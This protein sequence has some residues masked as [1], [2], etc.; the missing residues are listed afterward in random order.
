MRKITG[1]L[2]V[3]VLCL[4]ACGDDDDDNASATQNDTAAATATGVQSDA[5]DEIIIRLTTAISIR[6]RV[7]SVRRRP[8]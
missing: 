2:A 1:L 3:S 5:A 4:A 7:V 6:T 8:T